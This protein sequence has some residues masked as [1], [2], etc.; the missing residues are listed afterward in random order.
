MFCNEVRGWR[1]LRH[2]NVLPLLGAVM[3]Q[4]QFIMVSEWMTN[5]NIREFTTAHP[6]ANRFELVSSLL[7]PYP[8]QSLTTIMALT[9][10]RCCEGIGPPAQ[11]W[12]HPRR[13]KRGMSLRAYIPHSLTDFFYSTK[14]NILIDQN[15][16]ARLAD[17][18]LVRITSDTASTVSSSPG[19]GTIRWMSPELLDPERFGF[20]DG[21]PTKPSDCYALGMV[22]CEVLSGRIPFPRHSNISVMIMVMEGARP[23]R[24]QGAKGTWFADDIWTT[25][26]HCWKPDPGDR[27]SAEDVHHC[28]QALRSWTPLPQM[29]VGSL[30]TDWSD[31][32]STNQGDSSS[33]QTVLPPLPLNPSVP[34]G[35]P[36]ITLPIHLLTVPRYLLILQIPSPSER[37][38]GISVCRGGLGRF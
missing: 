30:A 15:R 20:G 34:E 35:S 18:G 13:S 14:A 11:P 36:N 6:D 4:T 37:I 2:P 28:L 29:A 7:R 22:I 24:P 26:E 12:N 25:L 23:E 16:H 8:W 10:G 32:G 19:A 33:H 38:W 17:F 31:E 27:P 1:A 3:N 21:R 9:V 5:G